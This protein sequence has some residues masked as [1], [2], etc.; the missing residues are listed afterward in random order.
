MK[1]KNLLMLALVAA[2]FVVFTAASSF[3]EVDLGTCTG[4]DK[5]WEP[6]DLEMPDCEAASQDN[7]DGTS[8]AS[9][10]DYGGY[11]S[12]AYNSTYGHNATLQG[13]AWCPT[14]TGVGEADTARGYR[15][16]IC[17]CI[18]EGADFNT[19]D[20][21][22]ITAE[23]TT[24]G[25]YWLKDNPTAGT[26]FNGGN[27]TGI[28]TT[29]AQE[30]V[31]LAWFDGN[32]AVCN[33]TNSSSTNAYGNIEEDIRAYNA[34][35]VAYSFYNSTVK[36][37]DALE[38]TNMRASDTN[39]DLCDSDNIG[40]KATYII[41][42]KFKIPANPGTSETELLIDLPGMFL[43][44]AEVTEGADVQVKI[45]IAQAG[46]DI[47]PTCVT[48]QCYCVTT[49]ATIGC[50]SS[51]TTTK[52]CFPYFT[53]LSD[54]W[55]DGI[56]FVNPSDGDITVTVNFA[57]KTGSASADITLAASEVWSGL[58]STDT[59]E[60]ATAL[61]SFPTDELL[62]VDVTATGAVDGFGMCGSGSEANG[63]LPRQAACGKTAN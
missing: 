52:L 35:S 15:L 31:L 20:D 13:N 28:T 49:V 7:P 30:K 54:A 25:V 63:Y 60:F 8:Y 24:K 27:V 19:S 10:F 39:S 53:T 23:I 1:F 59:T 57:S 33:A 40:T 56:A 37:T 36:G 14:G 51:T 42:K 3:A 16:S 29:G 46:S 2:S 48:P 26:D 47:C 5:L 9:W 43:V 22:V 62:Y 21:Y 44:P 17:E 61:A 4:C 58:V 18:N 45:G 32:T 11:A 12:D 38:T 34:S 6:G 55:W 41:T 50:S